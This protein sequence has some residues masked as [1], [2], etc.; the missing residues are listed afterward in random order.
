MICSH[1]RP[2]SPHCDGLEKPLK[3]RLAMADGPPKKNQYEALN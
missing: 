1:E 2:K 3:V